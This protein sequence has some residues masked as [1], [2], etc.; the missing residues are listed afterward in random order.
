MGTG[1]NAEQIRLIAVDD[2]LAVLGPVALMKLNIEGL[3][4]ELLD[5]LLG[6]GGIANVDNLLIQFHDFVPDAAARRTSIQQQLM[7]T[8]EQLW[9]FPF[10]WEAWQRRPDD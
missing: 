2:E 3:E 9:D 6:G 8:H 10:V 5:A 1:P 4:F 7:R